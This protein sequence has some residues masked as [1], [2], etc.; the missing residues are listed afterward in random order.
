MRFSFLLLLAAVASAQT[1]PIDPGFVHIYN[2]EFAQALTYFQAQLKAAPDDPQSYNHVA[3]TLL[4]QEMLRDGAMESQMVSGN[5]PFLRRPKM[6][7]SPADKQEFLHCIQQSLHLSEARLQANPKDVDALFAIA[8]AD[9]LKSNYQF[10]VEKSW[11]DSL[12]AATAARRAAQRI[13]EID[14]RQVDAY[15]VIGLDH[16][17]VGSL[18]FYLR[19]IGSLGGFSGDRAGGIRELENVLKHG[20]RN[21]YDAEV[22]LAVIYRREKDPE[23]AIPLLK[24]LATRFPRNYLFRFEQVQMYSDAGD[25]ASALAVLA[26]MQMLHQEKSPGYAEIPSEKIQYTRANLLF[27]YGDLAPALQDLQQVTKHAGVL[28][29]N[30]A[31][32]AWLRLGQVYDLQGKHEDAVQAYRETVRT[33]PKS[34]AASEAKGYIANPYRRKTESG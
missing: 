33:A 34:E 10:L 14:P 28:D 27:W 1:P 4:F 8:A 12:K 13:L 18:P 23:K 5:N 9:G 25:K 22:M 17:I 26:E 3:Q 30:T 31:V 7:I 19:A 11:I 24:D 20:T 21:R 6:E 32:L 16:Y 15:F 29:L 2:N